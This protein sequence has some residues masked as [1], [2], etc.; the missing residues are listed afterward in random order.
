MTSCILFIR[1]CLHCHTAYCISKDFET[2]NF[3]RLRNVY[4]SLFLLELLISP[5]F[6]HLVWGDQLWQPSTAASH[7]SMWHLHCLTHKSQQTSSATL[8]LTTLGV[9]ISQY[10]LANTVLTSFVI[11]VTKYNK[12]SSAYE[13]LRTT[14]NLHIQTY[15]C[16]LPAKKKCWDRLARVLWHYTIPASS[17]LDWYQNRG[18]SLLW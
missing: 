5:L 15:H 9:L 4:I 7:T 16:N 2:F 13:S 11:I 17:L 6:P 10:Y 18:A 8:L 1:M 3:Q 12:C 14:K